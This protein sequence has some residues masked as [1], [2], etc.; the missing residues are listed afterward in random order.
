MS[1]YPS[2]TWMWVI[3]FCLGQYPAVD[4]LLTLFSC[5]SLEGFGVGNGS[6]KSYVRVQ[7]HLR[8]ALVFH[9]HGQGI[10]AAVLLL[11]GIMF[12]LKLVFVLD[13]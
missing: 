11:F 8:F 10:T 13:A 1:C 5:H 12:R 6:E 2:F 3:F 7:T 4:V 9:W